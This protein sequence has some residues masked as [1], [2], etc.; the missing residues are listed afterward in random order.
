MCFILFARRH[1]NGRRTIIKWWMH[2]FRLA[3]LN[4]SISFGVYLLIW[5]GGATLS[6]NSYDW[7]SL[8]PLCENKQWNYER[9]LCSFFLKSL[10]F[11]LIVGVV[12]GR[13]AFGMIKCVCF[14][15]VQGWLWRTGHWAI[16]LKN[17]SQRTNRFHLMKC[18]P[19]EKCSKLQ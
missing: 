10:S 12:W 13:C 2:S 9:R 19:R 5:D 18:K 7:Y 14:F 6:E 3:K 17:C 15:T 4:E 1:N 11:T 8:R 16:L